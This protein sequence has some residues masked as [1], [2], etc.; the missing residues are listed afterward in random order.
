MDKVNIC[1]CTYKREQLLKKC[2]LSLYAM[3]IPAET[4]VTI[5]VIDNHDQQSA[6]RVIEELASSS[7]LPTFYFSEASRGIPF[8]RNRALMETHNIG[9]QFLVF[10][11]DDEW[12]KQDWLTQ[13]YGYCIAKG[14]YLVISGDVIPEF[15]ADIPPDI[16][17][18]LHRKNKHP[19]GKK[20]SSCAT[21]NVIFPIAIAQ[22]LNLQFNERNPFSGGEDTIFFSTMARH[23]INIEK[24]TEAL[25]YEYIPPSRATLTWLLKRKFWA[26]TI[27]AWRKQQNN[28]MW[29]AIFAS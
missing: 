16:K 27:N 17:P 8:A 6:K 12:V 4:T 5:S 25:V 1:I 15:P 2:L 29:L 21:N 10:I 13:L 28:K 22:N 23:G 9:A 20:L 14:G 19:T 7:T 18:L 3:D 26:G 24:C 11:D